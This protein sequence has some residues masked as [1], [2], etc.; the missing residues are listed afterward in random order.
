MIYGKGLDATDSNKKPNEYAEAL[1]LF[2]K[3]CIRK[4]AYDLKL[5]GQCAVQIIYS[6][7]RTKVAQIE[8][9]P[10][11]TIAIEKASEDGEVKGYYYFHDWSKIKPQDEPQKDTCFWYKQ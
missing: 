2:N 9:L 4:L 10:V 1:S 3:D 7:D 11:E 8:H 6:K 5:M